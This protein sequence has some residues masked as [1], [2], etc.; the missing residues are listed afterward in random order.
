MNEH[1]V[2]KCAAQLVT[3]HQRLND[4][5]NIL[6]SLLFITPLGDGMATQPPRRGGVPQER[7]CCVFKL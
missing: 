3:M 7:F 5:K 2:Y 1:Q 4:A 6:V